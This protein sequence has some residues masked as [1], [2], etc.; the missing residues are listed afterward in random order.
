MS[1][2]NEPVPLPNRYLAAI[3]RRRWPTLG[4]P[5]GISKCLNTMLKDGL[6]CAI[7]LSETRSAKYHLLQITGLSQGS[8]NRR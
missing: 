6:T 5:M 2:I 4:N 8:S 7:A 3:T 1:L